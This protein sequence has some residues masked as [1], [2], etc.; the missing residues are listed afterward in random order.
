MRK[1]KLI[2]KLCLNYIIQYQS[3]FSTYIETIIYIDHDKHYGSTELSKKN[4]VFDD[5]NPVLAKT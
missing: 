5:K 3:E 1:Q 4:P 2:I